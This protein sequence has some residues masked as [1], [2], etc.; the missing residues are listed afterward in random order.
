MDNQPKIALGTVQFG[1]PY[2]IAN[3]YGQMPFD[4][5]EKIIHFAKKNS[6]QYLDT[7]IAYGNSESVL[8]EIGVKDFKI[9]SKIPQLPQDENVESWIQREV[10]SS[11]NRLKVNQLDSLLLHRSVDLLSPRGDE[12][13]QTLNKLKDARII[14]NF[15]I[16]IYSIHELDE[17]LSRYDLDTI[18]T[19][20]NLIDRCVE[21][22]GWR[23]KLNQRKIKVQAR[24]LFLQGL[25]LM[26]PYQRPRKF[27]RW[28]RIWNV[29]DNFIQN[30]NAK[31]LD[32]CLDFIKINTGIDRVVLGVDSLSH[33][34]EILTSY[35]RPI[36]YEMSDLQEMESEDTDLINPSNWNQ[37]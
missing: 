11:L 27:F 30:S 13:L 10:E 16:S 3:R 21:K 17:C 5:A 2:G 18:Q 25:L 34:H 14:S 28:N 12:F 32:V 35:N 31:R 15:G 20:F 1:M 29:W 22:S 24:S 6:I 33:L 37:L 23:D 26:E 9:T 8:G 7:A 19:P 4:E 36:K